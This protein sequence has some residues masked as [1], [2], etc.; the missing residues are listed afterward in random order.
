MNSQ[1]A[2]VSPEYQNLF[3]QQAEI[4]RA[5]TKK[6]KIFSRDGDLNPHNAYAPC[7][8]FSTFSLIH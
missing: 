8:S 5:K 4:G 6:H 3:S 2:I 1:F 7:A